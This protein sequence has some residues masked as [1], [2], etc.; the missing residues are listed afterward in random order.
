MSGAGFGI[1][2]KV[3]FVCIYIYIIT[4]FFDGK[5]AAVNQKLFGECYQGS[6]IG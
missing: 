3:F 6:V 4:L 1:L 5:K 2:K